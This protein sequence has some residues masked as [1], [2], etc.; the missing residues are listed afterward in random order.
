MEFES[1]EKCAMSVC[2]GSVVL[3]CAVLDCIG[4]AFDLLR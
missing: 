4:F 1:K 2:L 3:C